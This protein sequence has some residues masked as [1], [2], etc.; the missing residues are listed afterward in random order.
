MSASVVPRARSI[1]LGPDADEMRRTLGPLAWAALESLV[2]DTR[3]AAGEAVVHASIRSLADR[4]GVAKNTAHRAVSTLRRAGLLQHVPVRTT[5]G[6][7]ATGTYRLTVDPD[8][9]RPT[10]DST[11]PTRTTTTRTSRHHTTNRRHDTDDT[12]QLSLLTP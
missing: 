7:F 1:V 11:T 6:Q 3:P 12:N 2:T 8:V 4:L 5:T 9:L 10:N